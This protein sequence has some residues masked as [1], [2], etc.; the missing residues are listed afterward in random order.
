MSLASSP[1][2]FLFV[3]LDG[4][5][6]FPSSRET[7]S[8]ADCSSASSEIEEGLKR[9][10]VTIHMNEDW[11]NKKEQKFSEESFNVTR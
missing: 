3:F 9:H 8:N 7:K 10:A 1:I 11:S 2:L 4:S 6:K 5:F